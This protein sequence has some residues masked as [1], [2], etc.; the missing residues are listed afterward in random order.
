[1]RVLFVN[2]TSGFHCGSRAACEVIT[3]G[4]LARDQVNTAFDRRRLEY[5]A[6]DGREYRLH[7]EPAT[8]HVRPRGLHLPERHLLVDGQPTIGGLVDAGLYQGLADLQSQFGFGI[9]MLI[10][11]ASRNARDSCSAVCRKRPSE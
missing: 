8:L 9:E 7:D 4:V 3:A 1:M 5:D 6:P 11:R 10:R 2:D